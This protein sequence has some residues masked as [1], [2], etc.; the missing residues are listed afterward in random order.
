MYERNG[1]FTYVSEIKISVSIDK[2]YVHKT[3]SCPYYENLYLTKLQRKCDHVLKVVF[4]KSTRIFTFNFEVE[5]LVIV[6]PYVNNYH[7]FSG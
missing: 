3:E 2:Q 7:I 4:P 5:L 1:K 6:F